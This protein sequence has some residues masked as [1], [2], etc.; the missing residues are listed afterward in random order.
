MRR[1]ISW[2][3]PPILPADAS[4]CV[5]V[6]VAR[7]NMPYSAVIQPLPCPRRNGGTRS[8]TDAVQITRVSPT[9]IR[10]DP[11][12]CTLQWGVSRRR[13]NGVVSPGRRHEGS[14]GSFKRCEVRRCEG[15]K[16]RGCEACGACCE[17]RGRVSR[18]R[19]FCPALRTRTFAP[20]TLAPPTPL[21]S[22]RD[23]FERLAQWVA[24]IDVAGNRVHLLAVDQNLHGGDV[25]EVDRQRIHDC[26]YRERLVQ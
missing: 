25:R 5:R 11:S 24:Q 1:W 10:T 16:V 19:Q 13:P 8:S 3:R 18:S 17:N 7:G 15:A 6:D 22:M 23:P 21:L 9:S 20:R 14:W 4:R 26:E 2:V 12:A